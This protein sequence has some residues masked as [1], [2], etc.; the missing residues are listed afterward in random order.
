MMVPASPP[1]REKEGLERI[2]WE[3]DQLDKDTPHGVNIAPSATDRSRVQ[4]TLLGPH[5]SPYEGG[6]FKLDWSYSPH[7][8][9]RQ[10]PPHLSRQ[11]HGLS[12]CWCD[13]DVDVAQPTLPPIVRFL[14]RIY[15]PSVDDE[16]KLGLRV[17]GPGLWRKEFTIRQILLDIQLLLLDPGTGRGSLIF[18]H[19]IYSV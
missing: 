9:R 14:T 18:F 7:H 4:V 16:G 3:L 11:R 19:I 15:H 17:L 12:S 2:C 8:V 10:P 1:A 5:G 13:V 6:I